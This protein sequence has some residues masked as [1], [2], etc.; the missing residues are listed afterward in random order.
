MTLEIDFEKKAVY[1]RAKA[2]AIKTY[3]MVQASTMFNEE[4]E[5]VK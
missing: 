2:W 5:Y 1:G 4:F 3:G